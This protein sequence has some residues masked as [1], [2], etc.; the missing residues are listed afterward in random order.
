MKPADAQRLPSHKMREKNA[1]PS[2]ADDVALVCQPRCANHGLS[3][4]TQSSGGWSSL[5]EIMYIHYYN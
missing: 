2:T 4:Y 3:L 5:P 1:F